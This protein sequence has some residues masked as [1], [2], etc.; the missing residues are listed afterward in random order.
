MKNNPK[1]QEIFFL[2]GRGGKRQ[3]KTNIFKCFIF[4]FSFNPF[5]T[6]MSTYSTT[7]ESTLILAQVRYEI[8]KQP[9]TFHVPFISI[10]MWQRLAA[11]AHTVIRT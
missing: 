7:Y 2:E 8:S 9:S 10:L 4:P 6:H 3:K 5:S 1:A 11:S